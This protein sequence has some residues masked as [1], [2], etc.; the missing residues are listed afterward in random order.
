M[1]GRAP[2]RLQLLSLLPPQRLPTM[3][4]WTLQGKVRPAVLGE[5][6]GEEVLL[7]PPRQ[8]EREGNQEGRAIS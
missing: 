4:G 8:P 6:L 7:L 5:L 1:E 2:L 3:E